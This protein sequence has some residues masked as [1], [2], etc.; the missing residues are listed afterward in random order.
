MAIGEF[1]VV[2]PYCRNIEIEHLPEAKLY[3]ETAAAKNRLEARSFTT[4]PWHIFATFPSDH[5][6]GTRKLNLTSSNRK[7]YYGNAFLRAA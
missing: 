5:I 7:E 1:P 3:A 6:G 4:R 2:C